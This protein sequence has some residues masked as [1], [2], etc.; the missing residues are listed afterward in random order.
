MVKITS[1]I[2]LLGEYEKYLE[3]DM[4]MGKDV[5]YFRRIIS[6]FNNYD[7]IPDHYIPERYK[8][9]KNL[10]AIGSHRI[11]KVTFISDT[12][13]EL[14]LID[15]ERL[16]LSSDVEDKIVNDLLT[17]YNSRVRLRKINKII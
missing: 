4:I 1:E 9:I 7:S 11:D 10:I 12:D 2:A 13:C 15:P 17:E 14:F 5:R 8:A 16:D 3:K 6:H